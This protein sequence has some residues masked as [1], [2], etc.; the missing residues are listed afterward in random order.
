MT[1]IGGGI[2]G[3]SC[4]YELA[5]RGYSVRLFDPGLG[6]PSCSTGNGGM[7]V[8][9]HFVPMASPGMLRL[10]LGMM[11]RRDAP[12]AFRWSGETARWALRF[13]RHARRSPSAQAQTALR[14]LN[15]M[16]RRVYQEWEEDLG[17]L[18]LRTEG[19]LMLCESPPALAAERAHAAEARRLGLD[20][21]EVSSDEIA[22]L[23][24]GVEVRA[25][26]GIHFRD[27]AWLDPGQ[28]VTRLR[29]KLEAIGATLIPEK[30]AGSP[31]P[32]EQT[33]LATGSWSAQVGRSL[34]LRLPIVSG[35][36]YSVAF[37]AESLPGVCA[38]L[39]EPRVAVTP[40]SGRLRISGTMLIGETS[41]RLDQRRWC[42]ALAGF[43]RFYPGIPVGDAEVWQGR[44]PCTPD[45][46]PL[47]GRSRKRPDILVATGHAMIGM[48]SGPATG[49]LIAQVAAG[50][51][52]EIDLTRFDPDRYA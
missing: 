15:L 14:D 40:L 32:G 41:A 3:L 33:V 34:G 18:S 1:V 28:V 9:S 48:S 2:V 13:V 20:A 8:P 39:V 16:S 22:R 52:P 38:I 4:A 36:G 47:I 11:R 35:T 29:A 21:P 26:G 43:R 30:Y 6:K 24:P 7:I 25:L 5:Q 50:E 17:A 49:R 19:L 46:L 37:P 27:D 23:N 51:P 12:L 31:E 45:G 10:G 42:A 44:R